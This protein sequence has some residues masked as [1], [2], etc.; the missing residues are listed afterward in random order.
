MK[1]AQADPMEK[2][3]A[4]L[5][6]VAENGRALAQ[7]KWD[8]GKEMLDEVKGNLVKRMKDNPWAALGIAVA[9]GIVLSKILSRR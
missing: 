7:G 1:T 6:D 9:T 8:D 5:R 4:S 2:L 3:N